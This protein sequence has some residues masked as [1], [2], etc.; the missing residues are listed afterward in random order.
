MQRKQTLPGCMCPKVLSTPHLTALNWTL[1]DWRPSAGCVI[2]WPCWWAEKDSF[3]EFLNVRSGL[4]NHYFV[5]RWKSTIRVKKKS[6][7]TELQS[8]NNDDV[9]YAFV[10]MI[11]SQTEPHSIWNRREFGP[12]TSQRHEAALGKLTVLWLENG[13]LF[14]TDHRDGNIC[15]KETPM[16]KQMNEYIKTSV[17]AW[18]L[19]QCTQEAGPP[20]SL[21]RQEC[22]NWN[23]VCRRNRVCQYISFCILH[24]PVS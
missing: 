12:L 9:L 18:P 11:I 17:R 19:E 8:H 3:F 2:C 21:W 15:L 13:T 7:D 6:K 23:H 10:V 24:P 16:N 1:L 22:Y 4:F 14:R 20:P 5:G